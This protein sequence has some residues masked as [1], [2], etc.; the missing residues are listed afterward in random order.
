[1]KLNL[2][3]LLLFMWSTVVFAAVKTNVYLEPNTLVQ[4]KI[5]FIY[6]IEK[7]E[8]FNNINHYPS[9]IIVYVR[10]NKDFYVIDEF[11]GYFTDFKCYEDSLQDIIRKANNN[12]ENYKNYRSKRN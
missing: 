6:N 8:V 4:Y 1:M 9:K 2:F 10:H 5:E 7:Y 11:N 3:L 12:Y